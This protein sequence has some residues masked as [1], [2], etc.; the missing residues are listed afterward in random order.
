VSLVAKE[1]S[2]EQHAGA[3]HRHLPPGV[4]LVQIQLRGGRQGHHLRVGSGASSTATEMVDV[5]SKLHA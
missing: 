2:A 4:Q 1:G 5:R 3:D